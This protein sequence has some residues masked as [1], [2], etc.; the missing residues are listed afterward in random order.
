[1][2]HGEDLRGSSPVTDGGWRPSLDSGKIRQD[3]SPTG[4]INFAP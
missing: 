4:K 2:F 3:V 1:M